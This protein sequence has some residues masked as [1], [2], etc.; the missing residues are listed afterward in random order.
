MDKI[1]GIYEIIEEI[2]ENE[3]LVKDDMYKFYIKKIP[4][5]DKES[6][7]SHKAQILGSISHKNLISFKIDQDKENFYIIRKQFQ[8]EE[9]DKL[10]AS[11]FLEYND[12]IRYQK[13]IECYLQIFEA[14]KYVHSQG[15]YHGNINTDNVIV[16]RQ[17]EV[18]L[19]DFGK[20]HFY[21]LLDH[22][23]NTN[24]KLFYSPE[25]L[26]LIDHDIDTKSDI[27][28]FGLCM[29]KLLLGISGYLNL[30]QDY[31]NPNDLEKI[32]EYI[33]SKDI[34][35]KNDV[36]NDLFLLIRQ[37]TKIHPEDRISLAN[38][39]I[40]LKNILSKNCK[41]YRFE[42]HLSQDAIEKYKEYNPRFIA[43]YEVIDYIES[44]IKDKKSYWYF[45]KEKDGGRNEIRIACGEFI[46][47]CSPKPSHY[48]FCFGI[49]SN[50]RRIEEAYLNGLE[51]Y[52][53]FYITIG[54]NHN[55]KCDNVQDIKDELSVKFEL[56]QLKN[57]QLEIDK[58]SILIEE[59]LLNA[60]KKTLDQKKNTK[61][62][63]LK[64]INRDSDTIIFEII[65]YYKDKKTHD[66]KPKDKVIIFQNDIQ[67]TMTINGE[68]KEFKSDKEELIIQLQKYEIINLKKKLDKTKKY[69]IAYDYQLKEIL[70]NKR[71]RAL[72]DIKNAEVEIPNLLRKIN[73]PR[74]LEHNTLVEIERFFDSNLD[75]NQKEAAI[76]TMSLA[77]GSEIL[78]I[79]GPPGT[80]KTTTIVEI[81]KQLLYRHRHWKILI[82]SQSNQA[83]DNVLEKIYQTGSEEKILRIGNEEK[84]SDIAKQFTPDKVL[85]T[86]IKDNRNRIKENTIIDKNL[87]IQ[88]ELQALQ[89]DFYK[90]LQNITSKLS[91]DKGSKEYNL[92]T[93]FIKNIRLVF[94]TLLGI[95][96]WQNF[97]DIAFDIVIVDEAGRATLS[98]FLVP[99]V[100]ARKIVFVGDHKQLAPVIDDEIIKN[101]N[102]FT[103]QEVTISFFER[104]FEK[105]EKSNKDGIQHLEHFKHRLIYNYRAEDRICQLYNQPFYGG[106]LETAKAIEGKRE[107]YLS[108]FNSSVVW[109]DTSKRNDRGD[110]QKG[111]GKIN[112]CNVLVI[113]Y[114]LREILQGMKEKNIK[115]RIRGEGRWYGNS[116]RQQD[117]QVIME[118]SGA[119]RLC[120][121]WPYA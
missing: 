48:L 100:K 50:Q 75:Y 63:I 118:L 29:L 13:L 26:E 2:S 71:N 96:S 4:K 72:E 62:A 107:H 19:L 115:K 17:N 12:D 83:V 94:G 40:S 23:D 8:T 111:T 57:Q 53:D 59:E 51:I 86:L 5:D 80:G 16:N 37:M 121:S 36:Q 20:S 85:D 117:Y 74:V 92:A 67:L 60:E 38:L 105:L 79:Q 87:Q 109:F 27:F 113:E 90:S 120:Q 61:L 112:R 7:Y 22:N 88:T 47:C 1:L 68:V 84:M 116:I 44:I 32:F 106:E 15:L 91:Q 43:T 73:E 108:I 114:K 89:K 28:S 81:V 49:L 14:I 77:S 70:W 52:N 41:I 82:A 93:L 97:R 55:Y 119:W 101:L 30:L 3:Y 98:E 6:I 11:I 110:E 45:D 99:C 25:Q 95:S 66:L 39:G 102:S 18:F 54:D 58:K 56:Q 64:D 76:K 24:N 10:D 69:L 31:H 35:K 42:L 33:I 9:F 103:K 34:H 78:L 104:L 21:G 65:P 46:F